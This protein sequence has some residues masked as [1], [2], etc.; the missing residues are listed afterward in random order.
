MPMDDESYDIFRREID[1]SYMW[2]GARETFALA[3]E[4]AVQD[5]ASSDHVFVIVNTRTGEKVF[6]I[7]PERP[8]VE[9]LV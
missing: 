8:P 9:E 2:V 5:P 3:R 4:K 6:V 7:P 1:G